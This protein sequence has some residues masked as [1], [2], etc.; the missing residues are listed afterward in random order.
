MATEKIEGI[1]DHISKFL[2]GGIVQRSH[3]GDGR[4]T[5][6]SFSKGIFLTS[7]SL[8]LLSGCSTFEGKNG[9]FHDR[10]Q[11][12]LTATSTAP[13]SFPAGTEPQGIEN[14]YPIP[15]PSK[16]SQAAKPISTLP[17][18]LLQ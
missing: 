8:L 7:I 11:N 2:Q 14:D 10:T 12:Y 3:L 6:E 1:F 5:A 13:L 4:K 15:H 16:D 18:D 17:P 9:Y